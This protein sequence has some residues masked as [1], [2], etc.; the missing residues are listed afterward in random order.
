MKK[1]LILVA[2]LLLIIPA[3][4]FSGGKK[5]GSAEEGGKTETGTEEA[6]ASEKAGGGRM[7]IG[8][9]EPLET[10]VLDAGSMY[11]NWGCLYYMLIYDN[12]MKFTKPPNY[13]KFT[14]ELAARYDLAE[15]RMSYVLH[16][17][18]GAK[19]HDGKPLTAEDVKFSME[20]LWSLPAWADAEVDYE[21]I[22]IIDDHTLR[23][24]SNLLVSGANP[25]PYWAWD[26][27][28]PKHIFEEAGEDIAAWPV[29]DAVGSG[30]FK[31]KEF[32]PGEFM[33]LVRN[34]GYWGQK[35]YLDEVVFKYYG[36][37]DTMIMALRKGDI[38]V[39]SDISIPPHLI[40]NLEKDP[41]INVEIVPGLE[42][43]WLSFNLH[44]EGP[45]QD[46]N[47]RRAIQYGIDRD[48]VIDMVYLGYAQKYNSW[49][50]EE[51]PLYN[52][53]LPAYEYDPARARKIL[54]DAG[55]TDTD[56]DGLR[57]DPKT[58]ENLYF[59]LLAPSEEVYAVKSCTLI[60]EMLPEVGIGIDFQT[61]DWDTFWEL[62]YY[63]M[64][65]AYEIALSSEEPAPAPYADW[66]W[67]EASSWD[68]LGEEWNSSYYDNPRLDELIYALSE[69][70]NM[71]ERREIVYEMQEIM[72]RDLPYGFL[73]R[74]KFIS[75]YRTDKISGWVNQIGGPVSWM[76]DWSILE[77][78]LK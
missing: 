73:V 42:L 39:I 40:D 41:N 13:Y 70:G 9:A 6:A 69:A 23:V 5:E 38:D 50:Y 33:W 35:P 16:I 1:R 18:E 14:P 47:V 59:E 25:P 27:V 49:L 28:V 17:V 64:E 32:Q 62:V 20:Q 37:I 72:A 74:P 22:E 77:A 58:G 55:Y 61:T 75:V 57:N 53:N 30:P 34:D 67:A 54:D 65:D 52:K 24:N 11:S 26:P 36:N 51:D 48:R 78:K 31:L 19:W 44:K 71:D 46:V 76:N 21:S 66:I 7:T 3:M 10:L 45:L 43:K 56:G 29:E 68:E 15:D 2:L 60:A 8:C 4:L 12:L 63:P